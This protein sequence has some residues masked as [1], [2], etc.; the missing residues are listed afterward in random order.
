MVQGI[1]VSPARLLEDDPHA[2]L[3]Q[4]TNE[5]H[6]KAEGLTLARL[7]ASSNCAYVC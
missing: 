5:F 3:R 4:P 1:S 6:A 7:S 2:S